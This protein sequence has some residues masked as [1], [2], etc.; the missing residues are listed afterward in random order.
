MKRSSENM[1]KVLA[2]NTLSPYMIGV[3]MYTQK[4]YPTAMLAVANH[5]L[6]S[7]LPRYE[8]MLAQSRPIAPNPRPWS[9]EPSC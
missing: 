9:P 5:G 8:D 4:I 3:T 1:G 7:G 2:L 6:A